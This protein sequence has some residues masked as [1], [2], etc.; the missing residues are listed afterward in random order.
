MLLRYENQITECDNKASP[1][2]VIV[3]LILGAWNNISC[4]TIRKLFKYCALTTALDDGDED[5]KINCF[6]PE[7]NPFIPI[8]GDIAEATPTEMLIEEDEE[9]DEE[10]DILF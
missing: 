1:Q 6:K 8:L 9:V 2:K 10:I 3:E 7:E 5:Y 4:E